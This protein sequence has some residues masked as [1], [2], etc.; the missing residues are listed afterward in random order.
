M[1]QN[2]FDGSNSINS[3]SRDQVKLLENFHSKWG[4]TDHGLMYITNPNDRYS[5]CWEEVLMLE[6]LMLMRSGLKSKLES[7]FENKKSKEVCILVDSRNGP[8]GFFHEKNSNCVIPPTLHYE[9]D[10]K[11]IEVKDSDLI[12]ETI[13]DKEYK[14][15][16]SEIKK[17]STPVDSVLALS[18]SILPCTSCFSHVI[19]ELYAE[20]EIEE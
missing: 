8:G 12:V 13:H 16:Y 1:V 17:K 20:F 2:S 18:C 5:S 6:D 15:E 10:G 4:I 7:F 19:Q 14:V 3:I 9:A 11:Y